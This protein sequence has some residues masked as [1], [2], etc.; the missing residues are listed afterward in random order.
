MSTLGGAIV[1]E[2][3]ISIGLAEEGLFPLIYDPV[4]G[5]AWYSAQVV[6]VTLG[7]TSGGKTCLSPFA[8]VIEWPKT[9]FEFCKQVQCLETNRPWPIFYLSIDEYSFENLTK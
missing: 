9:N 3:G 8:F 7:W 5:G 2:L 6:F 1:F 4:T